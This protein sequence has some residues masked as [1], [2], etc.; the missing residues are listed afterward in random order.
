MITCVCHVEDFS[1]SGLPQ[2]GNSEA[3]VES[4]GFIGKASRSKETRNC[5]GLRLE[6]AG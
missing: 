3:A 1:K 2:R 6:K 5:Q 4:R